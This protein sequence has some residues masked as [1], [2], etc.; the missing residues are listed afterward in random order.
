MSPTFIIAV[1][2]EKLS[3]CLWPVTRT[4]V[5]NASFSS[6]KSTRLAQVYY[7]NVHVYMKV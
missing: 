6:P 7:K 5:K 2:S 1:L 3:H 4:S